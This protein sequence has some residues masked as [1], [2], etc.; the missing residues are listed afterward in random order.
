[1]PPVARLLPFLTALP[2]H[3][4]IP[5]PYAVDADTVHLFHL[6]DAANTSVAANA[7]AGGRSGIV[8]DAATLLNHA[9]NAQPA[10]TT[11]LGA[12]AGF[13][14]AFGGAANLATANLGIGLDANSSSGFQVGTT[15]SCPDAV[16]HSSFTGIGGAFTIEAMVKLPAITGVNRQYRQLDHRNRD[17]QRD[18]PAG[19]RQRS[20][21][22]REF[23]RGAARAH[24]RGQHQQG[25]PWRGCVPFRAAGSGN[26]HRPRPAAGRVGAD[27]LRQPL[28]Q[29]RCRSRRR[30]FRQPAGKARRNESL[31]RV[32]AAH[33]HG[34]ETGAARRRRPR[35]QR[36]RATRG[37]RR[38]TRSPSCARR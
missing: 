26:R 19:H 13:S 15:S 36:L 5:G 14:S 18:R 11:V 9:T 1:M 2:L 7:V 8:F 34:G 35:H 22:H 21:T 38:S 33:R 28:T 31:R 17:R 3:A 25:G 27:L 12:T 30:W 24:R 32:F 6:D 23:Q 29:W 20:A 10:S 37:P 16:A 4:A